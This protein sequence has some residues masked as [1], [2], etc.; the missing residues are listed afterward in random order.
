MLPYDPGQLPSLP[1]PKPG[2][3]IEMEVTGWPPYKRSR[4]SLRNP[5][6]PDYAAFVNLRK[7]GTDAM[8]GRTWYHGPVEAHVEILGPR[9]PAGTEMTYYVGGIMDTLDGSHGFTFTYL[10]IVYEDD[11]Q[12][13][14][15]SV[16][17]IR[18]DTP[19]YKVRIVFL[20]EGSRSSFTYYGGA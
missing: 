2:D 13:C 8:R 19:R 17:F 16:R 1:A 11:C 3:T 4:L 7:A 15:G 5:R 10:P 6:N 20:P 12:V 9:L 14:G 18:S